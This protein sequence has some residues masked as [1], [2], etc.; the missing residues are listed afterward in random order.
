MVKALFVWRHAFNRFLLVK[1]E[2]QPWLHSSSFLVHKLLKVENLSISVS[3]TQSST[4]NEIREMS[5]LRQFIDEREVFLCIFLQPELINFKA[6]PG[7]L[8][9]F[10]LLARIP[11][12]LGV[13]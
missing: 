12:V 7:A 6:V 1:W 13:T 3:S 4:F 8:N 10:W 2:D 9:L 11:E 5:C